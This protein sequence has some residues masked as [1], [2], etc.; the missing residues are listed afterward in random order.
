MKYKTCTF[1]LAA[2]LSLSACRNP[3]IGL[4]YE[5]YMDK[6]D[7]PVYQGGSDLEICHGFGCR[8]R[9]TAYLSSYDMARIKTKFGGP[10]RHATAE[11]EAI[12]RTVGLI[13][14]IVGK[15]TGTHADIAGTYNRSGN[16]QFDCVDES[17]NTTNAMLVMEHLG[18]LRHNLVRKPIARTLFSSGRLGPH[19]SATVMEK[20]TTDIYAIDSWFFDNGHPA[21]V[22]PIEE[23]KN[24]Y[25]ADPYVK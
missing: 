7:F 18:L 13:E 3:E 9:S 1:I 24:G 12:A 16:D 11:R 2:C 23:W 17:V 19:Q 15:Q 21:V 14:E 8:L 22:V 5:R 10:Y 6:N 4:N 20:E 25:T